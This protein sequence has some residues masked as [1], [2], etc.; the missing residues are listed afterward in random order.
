M[1]NLQQTFKKANLA[2]NLN[3]ILS[4]IFACIIILSFIFSCKKKDDFDPAKRAQEISDYIM[5]LQYDPSAIL[6]VQNIDGGSLKTLV[7]SDT[8]NTLE[9]NDLI[10]CTE[11][12][13][14]LQQ[15]AEQV[16]I[17][18][19]T[20]GIIWPGALV[21]INAGLLNGM[22]EPVTLKPAPTTLRIDL[23]GI[24]AN[25]TILVNEPSNSNTQTE[26]DNALDWWNNNQYVE[27]YV[28]P[29]NSSYS[30]ATSFSSQQLAIDLGLNV[31]WTGGNVS[32]QFNYTSSST[33]KVAMMTF[34]QVFYTVTYDTPSEPGIV[35]DPSV[36]PEQVKSTFSNSEPPGY[37]HSV[38]YGRIIM[39]R[40]V[41]N[42]FA[43]SSEVEGAMKYSTGT[44]TVSATLAAK[45]KSILQNS[46]I[47]VVTIGGNAEVASHAVTAQDFGD[48]EPILTGENA[49]Y[50]KSN[51]G[52][53][54]AYTV[55]FLMDNKVAK[56]GYTTDYTAT[57]CTTS[58]K[59]SISV[60]CTGAITVYAYA[61]YKTWDGTPVS[62]SSGS[63]YLGNTKYHQI[64]GG[65]YD[66]RVKAKTSCF[67][68][69]R[70]AFNKSY[71]SPEDACFEVGGTV[72]FNNYKQVE[73]D[74][75]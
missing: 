43:T 47:E 75:K 74:F 33:N 54:I 57:E 23:P 49:V 7:N 28:N 2:K 27:G 46:S 12:D 13:Y 62:W 30:V 56:M 35:F 60:K 5:T 71:N 9:N 32:G 40:M 34:K 22:P 20:N 6:N 26:I 37:V 64:P 41:T 42:E 70:W 36:S 18:R 15:N 17:L 65:S 61:S 11:V 58:K 67:G 72:C 68:S 52:V 51:P 44:T 14:N 45:Y 21:K 29:S 39:F 31:K 38:S 69:D 66:I 8:A 10:V 63:I 24:G 16:A 25:G 3:W 53:P 48:L 19:P 50:S 4:G 59:G 55:K 73:C 1:K